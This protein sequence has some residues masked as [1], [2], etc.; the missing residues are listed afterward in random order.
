MTEFE[1]VSLDGIDDLRV[2]YIDLFLKEV[3]L[4]ELFLRVEEEGLDAKE[5]DVWE[6]IRNFKSSN[7]LN[8]FKFGVFVDVIFRLVLRVGK[9]RYLLLM[10]Y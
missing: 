4:D 10:N 3:E 5:F 1:K 2:K 7:R 8:D 9:L 6:F